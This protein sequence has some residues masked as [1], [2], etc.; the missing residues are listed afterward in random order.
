[1]LT[2]ILLLLFYRFRRGRL[3][4]AHFPLDFLLFSKELNTCTCV[5]NKRDAAIKLKWKSQ[6]PGTGLFK[7]HIALSTSKRGYSLRIISNRIGPNRRRAVKEWS[8]AFS[9]LNGN[10][11]YD[12]IERYTSCPEQGPFIFHMFSIL[13]SCSQHLSASV[14]QPIKLTVTDFQHLCN[15]QWEGLL[16]DR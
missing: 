3:F 8:I 14:N 2:F 15:C 4:V 13:P 5:H 10:V 11:N 6:W 16:L 9:D 12:N 7:F 1:M